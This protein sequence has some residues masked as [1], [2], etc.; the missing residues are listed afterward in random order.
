LSV[1]SARATAHGKASKASA[2]KSFDVIRIMNPLIIA[3]VTLR[4]AGNLS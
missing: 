4:C 3:P 1:T 2:A